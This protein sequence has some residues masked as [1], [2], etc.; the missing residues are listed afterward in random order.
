MRYL[1]LLDAGH[2]GLDANGNY[3]TAP[4]KMFDHVDFKIY[5]GEVNRII[6]KKLIQKLN[7]AGIKYR[8]IHNEVR[9]TPLFERV[10]KADVIYRTDPNSIYLSIHCNAGGG[11]GIEFYTSP[12][13][14]KSDIF[15]SAFLKVFDDWGKFR[16]RKDYSDGDADKEANFYVLR[17]T[18]CPALMAELLFFD[19]KQEALYLMSKK[20]TDELAEKLFQSI[21]YVEECI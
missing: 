21:L 13:Q 11:R 10:I 1:W 3:V 17:K 12:G 5:E 20:G 16:L 14:T 9:D 19:N 15:C 8:L 7:S 18:D 4:H 6:T 2:G